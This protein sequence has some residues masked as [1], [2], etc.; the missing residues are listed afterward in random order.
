LERL[1]VTH[2]HG[3]EHLKFL[4]ETKDR[5]IDD[6]TK[7]VAALTQQVQE[8]QG[9]RRVVQQG[10][11]TGGVNVTKQ[12]LEDA[13]ADRARLTGSNKKMKDDYNRLINMRSTMVS[14]DPSVSGHA[15]QLISELEQRLTVEEEEREAESAAY[16]AKLYSAEKEQC[17]AYVQ[18]RLVE[19][20]LKQVAA[21]VQARDELETKIESCIAGMFERMQALEAE[22]AHLRQ[23]TTN[24]DTEKRK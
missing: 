3:A 9:V 5:T 11:D 1:L 22:N 2:K 23:E 8:L 18:K 16:N 10:G 6:L 14:R 21:D 20:Q 19:H 15:Q 4:V 13:L 17:D 12:R 7:Q 24:Q